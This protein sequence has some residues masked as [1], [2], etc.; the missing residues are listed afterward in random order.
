MNVKKQKDDVKNI[1]EDKK[2]I[3]SVRCKDQYMCIPGSEKRTC[4][5]CGELVWVSPSLKDDKMDGA[6]C[7]RCIREEDF[8][9]NNRFMI[10]KEAVEEFERFMIQQKMNEF[11]EN[12][13]KNYAM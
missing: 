5:R 13:F 12:K 1:E 7:T 2:I 8:G 11:K 6:I 9:E 10:K 3:V 4:L